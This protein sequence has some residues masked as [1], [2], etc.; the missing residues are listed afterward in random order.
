MKVRLAPFQQ[1]TITSDN[2]SLN[3]S[4]LRPL[5]AVTVAE[6]RSSNSLMV[7]LDLTAALEVGVVDVVVGEDEAVTLEARI[8]A[9][10]DEEDQEEAE[11]VLLAKVALGI[12]RFAFEDLTQATRL[13]GHILFLIFTFQDIGM[14]DQ[15]SLNK[16]LIILTSK[17]H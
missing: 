13:R 5:A 3:L 14:T 9:L 7:S 12:L 11:G 17:Y 8:Q 1:V 10:E 6:P 15:W 4:D 2:N 16:D